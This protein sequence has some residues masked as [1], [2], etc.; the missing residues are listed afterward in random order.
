M[1]KYIDVRMIEAEECSVCDYDAE[2]GTDY[3][4]NYGEDYIGYKVKYNNIYEFVPKE[5]F[6]KEYISCGEHPTVLYENVKNLG[7]IK[8]CIEKDHICSSFNLFN[9]DKIVCLK[10]LENNSVIKNTIILK[11]F[12]NNFS[13]MLYSIAKNGFKYE[14]EW[15]K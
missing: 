11:N 12:L 4:Y 3:K 9:K 2:F 15:L 8:S 5:E 13:K 14:E 10:P 7:E 6:E 1:E